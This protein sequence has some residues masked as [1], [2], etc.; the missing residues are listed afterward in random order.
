MM[1]SKNE[2]IRAKSEAAIYA[3]GTPFKSEEL[4]AAWLDQADHP[5]AEDCQRVYERVLRE[6]PDF[7]P[8]WLE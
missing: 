5:E 8:G 4:Y 3:E 7:V 2:K 6:H 1:P